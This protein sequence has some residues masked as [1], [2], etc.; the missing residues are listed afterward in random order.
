MGRG[1]SEVGD[2]GDRDWVEELRKMAFLPRDEGTGLGVVAV[3]A[4]WFS[5]IEA[6][7]GT[8]ERRARDWRCLA[9]ADDDDVDEVA[10]VSVDAVPV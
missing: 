7:V 2:E 8:R 4:V 5:G 9:V 3:E 10:P 6:E 1:G